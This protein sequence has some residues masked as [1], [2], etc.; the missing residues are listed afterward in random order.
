MLEYI[1]AMDNEPIRLSKLPENF[2]DYAGL[3]SPSV[4]EQ[5]MSM[6]TKEDKYDMDNTITDLLDEQTASAI[7]R[8][9]MAAQKEQEE[10]RHMLDAEQPEEEDEI[11]HELD[12]EDIHLVGR[13]ITI[14]IHDPALVVNEYGLVNVIQATAS[15]AQFG[16][17]TAV[18]RINEMRERAKQNLDPYEVGGAPLVE[19]R[20]DT[21][22][23]FNNAD[24]GRLTGLTPAQEAF[25]QSLEDQIDMNNVIIE[26]CRRWFK[27]QNTDSRRF[28]LRRTDE[29]VIRTLEDSRAKREA[30]R[31]GNVN[32][33]KFFANAKARRHGTVAA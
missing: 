14:I 31:L 10:E 16:R 23:P 12:C 20:G 27:E 7:G 18:M 30:A 2:L 1:D 29:E 32:Q 9:L 15:N 4:E 26:D 6:Q 24:F 33:K 11:D 3:C 21:E 17:C 13:V 25:M 22:E 19:S 5:L 8:A 28:L